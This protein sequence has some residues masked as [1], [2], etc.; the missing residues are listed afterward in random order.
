[1]NKKDFIPLGSETN[2]GTVHAVGY[3]GGERYYWLIDKKGTVSMMPSC[4]V[5][6]CGNVKKE[7]KK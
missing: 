6:I 4:V 1:M 5:E 3:V 2:Y 7:K